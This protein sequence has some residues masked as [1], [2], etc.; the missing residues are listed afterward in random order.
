LK[1]PTCFYAVNFGNLIDFS[2]APE[3]NSKIQV[4]PDDRQSCLI[5]ELSKASE[6]KDALR[7]L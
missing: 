4:H 2:S 5:I 1:K 3:T 7:A 6:L